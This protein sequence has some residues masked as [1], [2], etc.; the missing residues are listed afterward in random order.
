MAF[1]PRV[2]LVRARERRGKEAAQRLA[3]DAA[4]GDIL[5]FSDVATALAPG[6]VGA[7]VAGFADPPSAA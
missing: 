2:R 4:D 5:V 1:A 3:I 7:I 6:A